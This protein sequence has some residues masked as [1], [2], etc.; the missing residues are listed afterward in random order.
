[1]K[2]QRRRRGVNSGGFS[3]KSANRVSV[4]NILAR[5]SAPPAPGR[6]ASAARR[7]AAW[8]AV[9]VAIG[10]LGCATQPETIHLPHAAGDFNPPRV[11]SSH[12]Q[13]DS[14]VLAA[15]DEQL[16]EADWRILEKVGP[17]PIWEQLEGARKRYKPIYDPAATG[18]ADESDESDT[19]TTEAAS[20]APEILDES[21]LPI[22][23][24]PLGDGNV[25]II[26][27]L[28][29][30]GGTSV[31]AARDGGTNRRTIAVKAPDLTSLVGLI[32]KW[33]GDKGTCSA[34]PAENTLVVTCPEALKTPLL[35]MLARLDMPARQV[36]ITAKIFEVSQDFDFQQGAEV[37][38][39]HL[40]S[41]GSQ[42]ALSTFSAKR[43]LDAAKGANPGAP[44]QGSVLSL[45]QAWESAGISVDITFQLLAES[46]L[47]QVVSSPR[48]TVAVGQT[49][50]MLAGQEL[51]I[52][53][54]N[55]A[56]G[57]LQ[58]ATTYKPV[59]VQLYITPQAAGRRR[60]KLHAICIV[61]SISGFAPLPTMDD[62]D[63]SKRLINPIIDSREA[64]TAIT[65]GYGDTLVISGLRMVRNAVRE[66]KIPWLGDIPGL[67]WMFKNHRT[68]QQNTDL[69]FFVSPRLL[70][71]D[72][73]SLSGL[74]SSGSPKS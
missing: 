43:F 23:V 36:E 61:S 4:V 16:S 68:Q 65:I 19:A 51:P 9:L 7:G 72:S 40:A 74:A 1:V 62:K 18:T 56:N 54:A 58:T 73:D 48:M 15:A 34:L 39:N 55:L 60:V 64:E 14:R 70:P 59:G 44:V 25:R 30:F 12:A 47:I 2:G 37:V 53:S 50:Y 71:T 13:R 3:E 45:M 42:S 8:I 31:T 41:D 28:R 21:S 22:T 52:Q 63:F 24:A 5:Q 27:V 38:L 11:I 10:L 33:R 46:G 29:N 67:E 17:R 6:C 26:W 66:N 49:G 32:Q 69:Y 57:V 35:G 20:E